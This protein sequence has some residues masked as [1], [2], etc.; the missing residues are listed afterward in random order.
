MNKIFISDLHAE[1]GFNSEVYNYLCSKELSGHKIYFIGDSRM[2]PDSYGGIEHTGILGNHELQIDKWRKG[3]IE[4]KLLENDTL[5]IHGHN[6]EWQGK[7]P[8]KYF[9]DVVDFFTTHWQAY[10]NKDKYLHSSLPVT[11]IE[12]SEF[13]ENHQKTMRKTELDR[14][15]I[16]QKWI[17]KRLPNVKH[18]IMGHHHRQY[19]VNIGGCDFFNCGGGFRGDHMVMK[20]CGSLYFCKFK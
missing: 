9:K 5:V 3:L 1:R 17:A 13:I 12:A 15:F 10:N 16:L 2:Y 4:Y 8:V 11:C 18:V 7:F 20:D 6:S 14:L 19:H